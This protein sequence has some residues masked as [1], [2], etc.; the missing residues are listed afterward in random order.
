M[1]FNTIF[2]GLLTICSLGIFF[3]LGP[4]RA[5]V[6][7]RNRDNRINWNKGRS[8]LFK[9]FIWALVSILGISLLIRFFF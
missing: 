6:K 7:Q 1:D 8:P 3:F 9:I 4:L 2:F 5:S